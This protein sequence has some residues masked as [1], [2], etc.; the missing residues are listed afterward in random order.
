MN[1]IILIENANQLVNK[2]FR[3]ELST[4]LKAMQGMTKNTWNYAKS[5]HKIIVNELYKED[6]KDIKT[7]AKFISVAP[8]LITKYC[9]AVE[10]LPLIE[11]YGLTEENFTASKANIIYS[12][13]ENLDYVLQYAVDHDAHLE[14]MSEQEMVKYIKELLNIDEAEA[15]AEEEAEATESKAD[16]KIKGIIEDGFLNL[17]IGEKF[18]SIPLEDLEDYRV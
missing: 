16:D 1:N 14:R 5:M 17:A 6:C 10:C 13:G 7:F 11:K 4:M 15:E 2:D 18:Y 9:H 12:L 3:K 8:S